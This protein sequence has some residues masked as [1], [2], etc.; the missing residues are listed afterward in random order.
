MTIYATQERPGGVTHSYY[1]NEY[2]LEDGQIVLYRCGRKR[3]FDGRENEWV[4]SERRKTS[5][6]IDDPD[7]PDWLHKYISK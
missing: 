6:T 4:H 5:W 7:L 1:W 3:I 2:R